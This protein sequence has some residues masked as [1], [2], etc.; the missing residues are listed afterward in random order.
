MYEY[1]A[2]GKPVIASRL[3]SV[4]AYFDDNSLAYFTPGDP[5]DLAR[6]IVELAQCSER[7]QR[8]VNNS[9]RLYARYQWK[10]QQEIY[11]SVYRRWAGED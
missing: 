9:Q 4:N 5:E 11:L 6:V 2:F 3:N 8:L 1:L 10:R 7:R